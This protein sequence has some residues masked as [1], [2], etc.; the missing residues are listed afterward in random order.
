MVFW[1]LKKPNLYQVQKQEYY[2]VCVSEFTD[3]SWYQVSFVFLHF[4]SIYILLKNK[5]NR[6]KSINSHLY[7][8]RRTREK[9]KV[10][11]FQ[12]ILQEINKVLLQ[13]QTWQSD[14]NEWKKKK[15]DGQESQIWQ[16]AVNIVIVK[17]YNVN[18]PWWWVDKVSVGPLEICGKSAEKSTEIFF[19]KNR[20]HTTLKNNVLYVCTTKQYCIAVISFL[21][22]NKVTEEP[23]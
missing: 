17:A 14:V 5:G 20:L 7:R 23:R 12:P 13:Y 6:S 22:F 15:S 19:F 11:S 21:W 16:L 9:L 4:Y 1:I 10:R 3:L 18:E 8:H 2:L